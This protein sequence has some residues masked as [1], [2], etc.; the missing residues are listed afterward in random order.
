MALFL[1]FTILSTIHVAYIIRHMSC[2]L[3][4]QKEKSLGIAVL[5]N[6]PFLKFTSRKCEN[7]FANVGG[8][9]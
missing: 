7:N 4:L 6:V 2:D 8:V 1:F 9:L 5:Q 3:L